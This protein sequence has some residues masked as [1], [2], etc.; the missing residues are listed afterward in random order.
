M[1]FALGLAI[2]GAAVATGLHH[3]LRAAADQTR[4]VIDRISLESAT[5]E[6]FGRI[7]AGEVHSVGPS[8]MN[9]FAVNGRAIVVEL[10]LPEGKR[11]LAGDPPSELLEALERLVVADRPRR[12]PPFAELESLQELATVW[13]LSSAQEDCLRRTVTVG[14]APEQFRPVAAAE[15]DATRT[16]VAGDQVDLRV[17]LSTGVHRK[18]LWTRARFTGQTGAPWRLHDYRP[19]QMPQEIARC[20]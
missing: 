20:D 6:A 3:Y 18:V 13:R 10:S 14:R 17:A 16:A 15:G 5:S 4:D 8:Q 2:L 7:A 12:Q 9:D 19:L 11:D 1:S